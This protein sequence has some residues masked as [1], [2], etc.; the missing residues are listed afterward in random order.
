[1]LILASKKLTKNIKNLI[2]PNGKTCQNSV[3]V[4]KNRGF[5][6]L[7]P[8]LKGHQKTSLK[9]PKIH[10]KNDAKTMQSPPAKKACKKD[11]QN[12]KIGTKRA[13]KNN[14][15]STKHLIEKCIKKRKRKS[16][17]TRLTHL[18]T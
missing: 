18:G 8:D 12:S 15:K 5:A 1:M 17:A 16:T 4:I 14:A 13:P 7:L 10:P 9:Q 3:R 6:S 11:A 2:F